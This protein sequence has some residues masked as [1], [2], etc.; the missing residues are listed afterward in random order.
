MGAPA[1]PT[2][3]RAHSQHVD[4]EDNAE[5]NN[6]T[7]DLPDAPEE[8]PEAPRDNTD[9][10]NDVNKV[11][12][13]FKSKAFLKRPRK[14]QYNGRV[15]FVEIRDV[16]K[17]END[18]K[19]NVIYRMARLRGNN[20]NVLLLPKNERKGAMRMTKCKLYSLSA[21]DFWLYDRLK[22][23]SA[24][25]DQAIEYVLTNDP[26]WKSIKWEYEPSII[27]Q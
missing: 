1:R 11:M 7:P 23:N 21:S 12:E 22:E 3:Q 5:R 17:A 27:L 25:V 9:A 2:Q 24:P 4:F 6:S 15:Y 8:E 18:T 16:M 13:L 20:T 19:I 14:V 26:K 10:K